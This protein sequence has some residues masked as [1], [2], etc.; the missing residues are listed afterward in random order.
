MSVPLGRDQEEPTALD[1]S[2]QQRID[3]LK[4]VVDALERLGEKLDVV[5]VQLGAMKDELHRLSKEMEYNTSHNL[6]RR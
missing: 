4:P 5:N 3:A 1:I 6:G 2:A